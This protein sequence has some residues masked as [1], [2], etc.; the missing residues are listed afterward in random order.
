MKLGVRKGLFRA[1]LLGGTLGR[2]LV[3]GFKAWF[4][5]CGLGLGLLVSEFDV[6][7]WDRVLGCCEVEALSFLK[8]R[9]GCCQGTYI[10]P[11]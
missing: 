3:I 11:P 1:G 8:G 9:L 2:V 7:I 6:G 4:G 10:K 5:V